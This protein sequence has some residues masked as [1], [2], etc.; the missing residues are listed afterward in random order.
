LRGDCTA[1]TARAHLKALIGAL[2]GLLVGSKNAESW[3]QFVGRELRDPGPAFEILYENLW[4]PGVEVTARLIAR[5]LGSADS[6]P[7]PRIQALLLIS[8]LL[9]FQSGRSISLRTMHW[10]SIGRRSWPWYWKA[11]TRRSR[12]SGG[13]D[14]EVAECAFFSENFRIGTLIAASQD[15]R[16]RRRYGHEHDPLPHGAVIEL[17]RHAVGGV[18]GTDVPILR[19]DVARIVDPSPRRL[20]DFVDEIQVPAVLR[21][22]DRARAAAPLHAL[23]L[24]GKIYAL[25][26]RRDANR[27]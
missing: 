20:T 18:D 21:H 23:E 14:L 12:R 11:W 15:R 25:R 5:I 7:P 4:R 16:G 17:Y 27:R 9:A 10:S 24:T 26:L 2:A 3:A 19:P 6:N 1:E 22:K 8:S 13:S